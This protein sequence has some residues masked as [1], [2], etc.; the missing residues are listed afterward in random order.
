MSTGVSIIAAGQSSYGLFPDR[1]LKE[2]FYDARISCFDTLDRSLEP[3]A[4]DEAFI[5]TLGTG[6]SQ[7]G[8]FAPLMMEAAG[9]VGPPATHVENACASAGF[10]FRAAVMAVASGQ[11]QIA[12]AGGI[13]KM[14]D[15]PRERNRS[16]LGVSGDVEW[17]RLAGTNFPGIYAMMARRHMFEHGTTKAQITGVAVKNRQNAIANPKA[18][19][20]RALDLEKA[21]GA[22]MLADPFT[23]SDACGITDGASMIIVA[24]DDIAQQYTDRPVKV[25]G[26]GGGTDYVA[27]HDRP[28]MTELAAA[29]RAAKQAYDMAGLGPDQISLAEVH[30][31]FTIGEI[32]SY[33]DLGFCETADA[34]RMISDGTTAADGRLPV[35]VSGGLIGK[36]HPIG[37]TGTGQ[38]YELFHQLRGTAQ[39]EGR[40]L[41]NPSVGLAHNVGGSGGVVAVT[42]LGAA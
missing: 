12:M 22:P 42:I 24:R 17:E 36:G 38:I 13:E 16:W 29:R 15:L 34:G 18:Q 23:L 10:A 33:G 14:S 40:Q 21:L 31:C 9:L 35:N 28:T 1:T 32:L 6:G 19:F 39:G 8:N 4:I 25:L 41:P 2:L 20:R 37:S 26:V 7:L 5:G 30:D 27:V 11:A 3:S